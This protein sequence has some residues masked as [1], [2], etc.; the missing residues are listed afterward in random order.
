ML[1]VFKD[2]K[3]SAKFGSLTKNDALFRNVS[4]CIVGQNRPECITRVKAKKTNCTK[5]V[6]ND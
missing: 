3:A 6:F 1:I 2:L 5:R 4:V